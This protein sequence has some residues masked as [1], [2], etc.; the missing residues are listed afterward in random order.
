MP[1]HERPA[2]AQA[3]AALQDEGTG[4][5]DEE[6]PMDQG[7]DHNTLSEVGSSGR[8]MHSEATSEAQR[9]ARAALEVAA[10]Q[11]FPDEVD[12]ETPSEK[13]EREAAEGILMSSPDTLTGD[14]G[15][16]GEYTGGEN[17]DDEN[18]KEDAT[19]Q[20]MKMKDAEPGGGESKERG[21]DG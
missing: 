12:S 2:L 16:E 8:S 13:N 14:N 9:A 21:V 4:Q 17:S 18:E 19:S 6:V 5:Q 10:I 20:A 1:V 11:N 7:S 3:I 15:E